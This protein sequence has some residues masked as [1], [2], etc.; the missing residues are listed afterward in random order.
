MAH[1]VLWLVVGI[2]GGVASAGFLAP[3]R[4]LPLLMLA[5]I[6]LWWGRTGRIGALVPGG[7]ALGLLI[8]ATVPEGPALTGRVAVQG[9]VAGAAAGR[10]ADVLVTRWSAGDGWVES[11]GRLRVRFRDGPPGPGTPVI[12]A[13]LAI[14]PSGGALPGAPD[15]VRALRLAK[16]RS[17]LIAD[18]WR[19]IGPT[20]DPPVARDATGMLR[21]VATGDRSGVDRA[22]WM[23]L[24]RTGTSH[25]LA[26]SGFHVGVVAGAVAALVLGIIRLLGAIRPVGVPTWPAL[27][28]GVVAA[29]AYAG[30]AGAPVSAQRAAGLLALAAIGKAT[31]RSVEV[32]PLLGLVGLAVLLVDPS[33]LTTPSMQLSFGAVV[34]LVRVSPLIQRTCPK[35]ASW[36]RR[37]ATG[38]TAATV[39]A[40]VGTLPPAAWWFQEIAPLS[41][42]ANLLAI[43]WMGFVIVPL[44]ALTTWGPEL[45]A[46]PAAWLGD[47]AVRLMLAALA[48]LDVAPV[49]PAVGPIGAVAL[50]G[51]LIFVDRPMLCLVIFVLTTQLRVLPAGA[52]VVTFLDVGQGDAAL[53]EWPDGRRWMIDGGPPGERVLQWLRRRG[54]RRLDVVVVTHGER[55]HAGG[56]LP[57]VSSLRVGE[58]WF[59]DPHGL[60]ELLDAAII[61]GA[62]LRHLPVDAISPVPG[63]AGRVNDRSLVVAAPDGVLFT[64]DIGAR[65]EERLVAAGLSPASVLKVSHHGSR[66]SSSDDLLDAVRPVVA[67]ASVGRGNRYGHPAQRVLAR[68]RERGVAVWRTDED[69]TVR[70]TVEDDALKVEGWRPGHGWSPAARYPRRSA[71]SPGPCPD[72]G[73]ALAARRAPTRKTASAPAAISAEIPCDHVRTSPRTS[74]RNHPRSASP[75]NTSIV[76][77]PAAYSMR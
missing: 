26:I 76:E 42:L 52:P 19:V 17:E 51:L 75:R 49:T 43:P 7:A 65:V 70:V 25:L 27:V 57:V 23:R 71:A 68:F 53:V 55:D 40:T 28:A 4:P 39:G 1:P 6:L 74:G 64:G 66:T 35:D 14:E 73:A 18:R 2:V 36:L 33:A 30:A 48:P 56:L 44:A 77:R 10:R 72:A 3:P 13:G 16:I 50:V 45:L 12:V 47:H 29:I 58:V 8:V 61:G 11:G 34:G 62:R 15:P 41:P 69:G 5:G 46:V 31:G 37:W 67:V 38:A 32:L 22:T 63:D 59:S 21:A 9:V 54:V 20:P 60:G 24:R